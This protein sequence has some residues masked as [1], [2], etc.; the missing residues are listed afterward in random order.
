MGFTNV[1]DFVDVD[2]INFIEEHDFDNV[3]EVSAPKRQQE[4]ISP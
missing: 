1:D 2:K 4:T 3:E